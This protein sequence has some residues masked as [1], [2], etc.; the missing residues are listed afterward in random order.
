VLQVLAAAPFE[1]VVVLTSSSW[2]PMIRDAEVRLFTGGVCIDTRRHGPH[3]LPFRIHLA[4]A[5]CY[6]L[7][8]RTQAGLILLRQKPD[9]HGYGPL[10]LLPE[11]PGGNDPVEADNPP[12]RT[13]SLAIVIRPRSTLQ[14]SLETTVWPLWCRLFDECG[15]PCDELTAPPAEFALGL[16]ML[17]HTEPELMA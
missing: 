8:H 2:M 17:R 3:V 13:L 12:M 9:A 16:E 11:N 7:D 1:G 5:A 4:A 14:D 15:V 10:A 6:R